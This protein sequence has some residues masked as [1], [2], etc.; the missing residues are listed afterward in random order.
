MKK[1]LIN[2]VL[3]NTFFLHSALTAQD[4]NEA[5]LNSLPKSIQEDFLNSDD[6]ETYLTISTIDLRHALE[7]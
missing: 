1:I 4:L 3:L 2:L 7:K 5:F 6:D